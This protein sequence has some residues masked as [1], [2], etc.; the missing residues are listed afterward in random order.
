MNAAGGTNP[1]SW[2]TSSVSVSI[3]IKTSVGKS[4]VIQF[5]DDSQF[6]SEPQ[7]TLDRT[8]TAWHVTHASTAQ[9]ET[10]LNGKAVS[11]SQPVKNGDELA[12]GRESKGIVKLPLKVSIN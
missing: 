2:L 11:G 7:F 1:I 8:G 6:W 9:N 4:A 10:L 3:R 12:V 5:G